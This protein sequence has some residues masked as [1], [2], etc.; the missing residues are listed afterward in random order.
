MTQVSATWT[1]GTFRPDEAVP[2]PDQT[3]VRLTVEPLD[4]SPGHVS[5][6]QRAALL[7]LI[8][9]WKGHRPPGDEDVDRIIDEYRTGKHG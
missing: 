7:D 4:A 9:I 1:G 6:D 8:G 5:P 2:L 3:R